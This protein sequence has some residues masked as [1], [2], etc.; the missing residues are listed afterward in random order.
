[1]V[2]FRRSPSEQPP[3]PVAELPYP[4]QAARPPE[5]VG[6][7]Q[8]A[9]RRANVVGRA[10]K[11]PAIDLALSPALSAI[12]SWQRPSLPIVRVN[13]RASTASALAAARAG[14]RLAVGLSPLDSRRFVRRYG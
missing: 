14:E 5:R 13:L 8:S 9:H 7:L 10:G 1:P 11:R 4:V 12:R 6:R 3:V 2:Q